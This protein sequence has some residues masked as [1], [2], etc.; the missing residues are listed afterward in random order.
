MKGITSFLKEVNSKII[1]YGGKFE[2]SKWIERY[3]SPISVLVVVSWTID[4]SIGR[5]IGISVIAE[6][7]KERVKRWVDEGPS[8]NDP[9][10]IIVAHEYL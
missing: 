7:Q 3:L 6:R 2:P 1:I 4:G 5:L 9:F 8:R 10:E